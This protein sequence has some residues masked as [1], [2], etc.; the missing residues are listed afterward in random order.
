MDK[1]VADS[2]KKGLG[3]AGRLAQSFIHSPLSPLFY[4]TLL[5][6]GFMGMMFTPRQE[7]P[8]ISVPM[9]DI[10]VNYPGASS[11]QVASMIANPLEKLMSEIKGIE[12]VYSASQRG[13]AMVTV[14][15]I[16]GEDMGKSLVKLYDKLESNKDKIPPGATPPLVKPKAVDDVPIVT[17]TLWSKEM[18]DSDLRLLSLDVMQR[19]KAVKNTSQ[20]F[21]TGGRP[22]Q[23]RVEVDPA[24]LA[25]FNLTLDQLAHTISSANGE[26]DAGSIESGKSS[27]DVYT[28]SFLKTASDIEN[29]VI[30]TKGGSV[31]YVRD[32]ADVI[33]GPQETKNVVSFYTGPAYQGDTSLVPDGAPAV[34]IAVA[35]KAGTNGVEV[36]NDVLAKI[37]TLKG[38]LIPD[39]VK[40][41]VTRNYGKTAN[42]KVNSLI[43]KLFFVTG[44]VTLLIWWFLGLRASLVVLIVIPNVI[45]MTVFVAWIL[46]FTIDR[47]SLFALIFSIGILVDDAI[48]VIENIYRR[49]LEEGSMSAETAVDAVREVGNPTILATLTVIAA[50]LP[51]GA[52]SGMMGPYMKPI[53]ILG[54]V[55]M[56]LSL[57]AAFVFTPYLAMRLKPSLSYLKKAEKREHKSN[58]KLERFFR[59]IL[60]SLI[61]KKRNG[62]L[63]LIGLFVAF[64]ASMSLFYFNLARVKVLPLDNKAEFNVVINMPEGTALPDTSNLAFKMVKTLQTLPEV[65][66][67]Q[68]Y[69]GTASPFNFNGLVRHY[70]LRQQPWE[71]DIQVELLDKGDRSKTSH[72][73]AEQARDLLTP[74][75]EATGARIQ[76]VE[77]P[78][79]PPVL[80]TMVA[81]IYG[82]DAETRRK[83]ARDMEKMFQRATDI[84]DVD[85]LMPDEYDMWRFEID[86][87]KAIRRGV[88]VEDI[89]RNLDM[90]MGGY[91]LGDVKVERLLEPRFIVLQTPLYQRSQLSQM[92]QLPI[93]SSQGDSLPIAELGKF[94]KVKHDPIIYHKDLQPVE[95]VTGDM[96][97]ALAA[98]VYGIFNIISQMKDYTAP[99]GVKPDFSWYGA[100]EDTSKSTWEWTGEWT[101]TWETFRDMGGAFMIALV[102][103]YI[104]VVWEFGNFIMPAIIMSPIPL[105]LI[106]I[107]PGHALLGK[108]FTATSMIGF[109]ALAGIIVRNSILLVEFSRDMVAKGYP[110]SESMILA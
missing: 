72:E 85:T 97:G 31:I 11:Q 4:F 41:A 53:P 33:E 21:I 100:P 1:R 29:L 22:E 24:R 23:I 71:A 47:V 87:E 42:N 63:F 50:L 43:L 67:L 70:Y 90:A 26:L 34:T 12:H 40:I 68:S 27:F 76:V 65:R 79:G 19:L 60:T 28:G 58:E 10:F 48:V 54:S 103:I 88:S 57:F 37:E 101:V 105:T 96:T 2:S 39:N 82:P 32:V 104:L 62:R 75:A 6:L 69:V 66:Q 9:V 86:R 61:T 30:G 95:F 81:E 18:D 92:L 35:K 109:I 102:L 52:V 25:G 49:W 91:K 36:A 20:T 5:G 106:G 14:Q 51:M 44:A 15:F 108:D 99:D 73:L 77:M 74:I 64:F 56:L 59:K 83:F 38:Q 110:V 98:P 13:S 89:N 16:V 55:A 80:Q 7:D 3:I 78:P 94:V 8:Q 107:V 45:M 17:L 46:G 84:T 93:P